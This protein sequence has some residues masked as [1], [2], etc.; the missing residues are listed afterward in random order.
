LEFGSGLNVLTGETGAGKSIVV[1]ALELL[2]GER[3]SSD[4]VKD[5]SVK[6]VVEGVFEIGSDSTA[7]ALLAEKGLLD[8]PDDL[9]IIRREICRSGG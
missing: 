6:S 7:A 9:V 2:V 1:D 5:A 3:I 8:E 4:M